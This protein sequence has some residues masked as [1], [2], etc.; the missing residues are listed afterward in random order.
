MAMQPHEQD[1][2]GPGA[3]SVPCLSLTLSTL[4]GRS[5]ACAVVIKALILYSLIK[6]TILPLLIWASLARKYPL[7]TIQPR[8]DDESFLMYQAHL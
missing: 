4:A 3:S 6:I 8:L 7:S 2:T 1:H 5:P